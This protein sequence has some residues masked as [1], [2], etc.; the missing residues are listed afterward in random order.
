[1]GNY[2]VHVSDVHD[3]PVKAVQVDALAPPGNAGPLRAH[4]A[5]FIRVEHDVDHG[6]TWTEGL[7]V[8]DGCQPPS[9]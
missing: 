9:E 8:Q 7:H 2:L 1:M 5:T 4:A 3:A 6:V